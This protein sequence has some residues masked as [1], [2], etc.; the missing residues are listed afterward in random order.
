MRGIWRV[1]LIIVPAVVLMFLVASTA[2][3]VNPVCYPWDDCFNIPLDSDD[4]DEQVSP[5]FEIPAFPITQMRLQLWVAG[6]PTPGYYHGTQLLLTRA[7][8]GQEVASL[9]LNCPTSLQC[10]P[11]DILVNPNPGRY[12]LRLRPRINEGLK[13]RVY[14]KFSFLGE[15]DARN[16][17][18]VVG[19]GDE[20][21]YV[22]LGTTA[23][24]TWSLRATRIGR[25]LFPPL[26]RRC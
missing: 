12:I 13:G 7:D 26:K 23:G 21:V 24:A 5:P 11:A 17:R 3:A 1:L 18:C 15:G 19:P 25:R 14:G 6:T 16:D 20:Q 22:V 10:D 2:H 9:T 8:T 4:Q